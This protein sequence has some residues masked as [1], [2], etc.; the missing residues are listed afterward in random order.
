MKLAVVGSRGFVN[1]HRIYLEL[2]KFFKK[3]P[4]L[5]LVSGGARG[6]DTIAEHFAKDVG[7]PIKVFH[8]QWDL[9]GR[10]AGYKRNH[11]I[12]DYADQGIAFWDGE[13]KGTAHSFELAKERNKKLLVIQ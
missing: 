8:A 5:E 13:S 10:S 4:D 9:Y 11:L 7:I 2:Y 6:V 1:K 3:Y 12:W